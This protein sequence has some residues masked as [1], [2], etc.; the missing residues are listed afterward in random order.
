MGNRHGDEG[1]RLVDMY[2]ITE[3]TVHVT[4]R[5]VRE[6]DVRGE[7][8][9]R[10]GRAISD[11]RVQIL[12]RRKRQVAVGVAGEMY[13]GGGGVT[14]GYMGRGEQTAERFIPDEYSV[15][16]GARL[17][18]TGDVGRWKEDGEIEYL[19]RID[20]QIKIRGFRIELGEIEFALRQHPQIREAVVV[21]K[22]EGP[23]QKRL[24][25][26]IVPDRSMSA[27]ELYELPN[28]LSVNH[29]N[30]NESDFL[31]KEIF[32]EQSYLKHGITL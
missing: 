29:L 25:G 5:R 32:E 2:G 30:K 9:S 14:R 10:I 21:A 4:Y 12:D 16:E 17:Y 20:H 31:Y 6:R 23:D 28:R 24:V 18:R 1:V 15:E 3:T 11:L 13:V 22:G 27:E 8:G 26:Y 19:G 7:A